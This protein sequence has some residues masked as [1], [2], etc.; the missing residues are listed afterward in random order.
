MKVTRSY[1]IIIGGMKNIERFILEK[2][3]PHELKPELLDVATRYLD[4]GEMSYP[5]LYLQEEE[6]RIK[7]KP[8]Y[9]WCTWGD[10][11]HDKEPIYGPVSWTGKELDYDVEW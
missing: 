7:G 9:S 3:L 11:D 4:Q 2:A 1:E 8:V 6:I 5:E 10:L